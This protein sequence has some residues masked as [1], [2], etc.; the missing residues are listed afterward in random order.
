M[1]ANEGH[2]LHIILVPAN[3][4]GEEG[5]HALSSVVQLFVSLCERKVSDHPSSLEITNSPE[6]HRGLGYPVLPLNTSSLLL[7]PYFPITMCTEF[8]QSLIHW[9]RKLHLADVYELCL[10]IYVLVLSSC[11]QIGTSKNKVRKFL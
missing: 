1:Q 4:E 11:A 5:Q 10:L 3:T 9:I 8:N 2:M 6:I 7:I